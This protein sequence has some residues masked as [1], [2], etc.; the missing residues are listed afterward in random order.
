MRKSAVTGGDRRAEHARH[1]GTHVRNRG[2]CG[3]ASLWGGV[4]GFLIF[5]VTSSWSCVNG[6]IHSSTVLVWEDNF[7]GDSLNET[8]WS[9]N[10]GNGCEEG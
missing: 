8:V 9:L 4:V 1:R 2:L 5:V 7:D 6:Q 3:G 10:T